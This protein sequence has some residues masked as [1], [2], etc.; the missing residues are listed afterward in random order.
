MFPAQVLKNNIS[1]IHPFHTRV[2]QIIV[3]RQFII[4]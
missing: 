4:T 2:F 1:L 3:F